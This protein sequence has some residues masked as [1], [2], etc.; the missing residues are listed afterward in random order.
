ML[1]EPYKASDAYTTLQCGPKSR[2]EIRSDL[3]YSQW[4]L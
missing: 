2:I 1:D 3:A 4:R